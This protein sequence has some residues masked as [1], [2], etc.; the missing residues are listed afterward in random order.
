MALNRQ[1]E[2]IVKSLLQEMGFK[3]VDITLE[4]VIPDVR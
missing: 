4:I 3:D 1:A 2:L